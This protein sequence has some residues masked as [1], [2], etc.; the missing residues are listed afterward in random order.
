MGISAR[1]EDFN[2]GIELYT[3]VP[4]GEW[5]VGSSVSYSE[6]NGKNYKF[7]VIDGFDSDGYTFKV[8]PVV[9]Y[10]LRD[11]FALGARFSYARGLSKVDHLSLSLDEDTSFSLD[12]IYSLRHSYSGIAIM[13]NYISL[14][15]SQRFALYNELQLKL[16]GS[17]AKLINGRGENLVGTYESTRD[18]GIG[19]SPGLV[20]FVNNYTAV[21]L[22][23]GVLGFEY[24]KTKQ[25]TNQVYVGER[26]SGSASFRINIFTISLGIA[27]YL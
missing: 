8:S 15:T 21:E 20:A 17:Q 23:V 18:I 7:L 12:D 24:S 10:A 3:F 1:A 13:R 5:I 25:K 27:F 26:S 9:A 4:K 22:S 11:N 19:L 16:G 14:G 6:F 2:R